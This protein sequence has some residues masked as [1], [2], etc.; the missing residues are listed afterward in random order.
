MVKPITKIRVA[1]TQ[2]TVFV[3]DDDSNVRNVIIETLEI[4]GRSVVGY[5]SCEAFMDAYHRGGEACLVVDAYLPGG[6]DGISLLDWL[7][8]RAENLPVVVI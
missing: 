1:Q 3:V 7:S 5:A 8:T 4:N 6:M 2:P